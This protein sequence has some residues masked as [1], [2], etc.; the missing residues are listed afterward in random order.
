M[1]QS[2]ATQGT[3]DSYS[4]LLY[5][6]TRFLGGNLSLPPQRNAFRSTPFARRTQGAPQATHSEWGGVAA[7]SGRMSPRLP[8]S[9]DALRANPTSYGLVQRGAA[10]CLLGEDAAQ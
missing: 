8:L 7:L 5:T 2:R 6:E 9:P 3:L 10:F 4:F 1:Q